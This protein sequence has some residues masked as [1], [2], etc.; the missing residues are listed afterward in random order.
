MSPTMLHSN[1]LDQHYT[2][3]A[4]FGGLRNRRVLETHSKSLEEAPS[5]HWDHEVSSLDQDWE[6]RSWCGG[7]PGGAPGEVEPPHHGGGHQPA[8][9]NHRR[10]P[11]T[12]RRP[13]TLL[14]MSAL[15]LPPPPG[16]QNNVS[17]GQSLLN[18]QNIQQHNLQNQQHQNQPPLNQKSTQSTGGSIFDKVSSLKQN[19][20]PS[21]T[22]NLGGSLPA[23]TPL[24]FGVNSTLTVKSERNDRD[25]FTRSGL[26]P[27]FVSSMMNGISQQNG[28]YSSHPNLPTTQTKQ[29]ASVPNGGP[30][31]H[32]QLPAVPKQPS[33]LKLVNWR[34]SSL[35]EQRNPPGY[36][37]DIPHV[38]PFQPSEHHYNHH[39]SGMPRRLKPSTPTKPSTLS[40]RQSTSHH[41][42]GNH[43]S[44]LFGAHSYQMPKL[45]CSPSSSFLNGLAGRTDTMVH[46]N[47]V[48][49][50][51]HRTLPPYIDQ[52]RPQL[53]LGR[54]LPLP[55]PPP[56]APP[57]PTRKQNGGF[58]GL[59]G[60][61]HRSSQDVDWI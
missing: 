40:L 39:S 26:N 4:R 13:S 6:H 32:R 21:L 22:Q 23:G 24:S 36:D 51:Q 59:S 14:N 58:N 42:N 56:P 7:W 11:Q 35:P 8:H 53:S 18:Q 54:S 1:F 43:N 28:T 38:P 57:S 15:S 49:G 16:Q 41:M 3:S 34:Q 60:M 33:A 55:P 31:Q 10:L 2:I 46:F 30:K 25:Q 52:R 9:H 5:Y 19:L 17:A 44:A 20:L 12:P 47:G 48:N 27:N 50:N 37:H 45:N 61:F 29:Q